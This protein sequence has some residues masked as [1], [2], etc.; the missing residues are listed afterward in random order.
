MD[1]SDG[2]NL[3][4]I[5]SSV[6]PVPPTVL[7]TVAKTGYGQR[8]GSWATYKWNGKHSWNIAQM[9]TALILI[10]QSPA[11]KEWG[12]QLAEIPSNIR[13]ASDA[14]YSAGCGGAILTE[15]FAFVEWFFARSR[16][17]EDAPGARVKWDD[18][19]P[20]TGIA[21]PGI[22]FSCN[23]VRKMLYAAQ[24]LQIQLELKA[25]GNEGST[26]C[27]IAEMKAKLVELEANVTKL[28]S[29]MQQVSSELQQFQVTS[30]I[31]NID[32]Q[33]RAPTVT[34]LMHLFAEC[35]D[36]GYTNCDPARTDSANI[37]IDTASSLDS[38]NSDPTLLPTDTPLHRS[39]VLLNLSPVLPAPRKSTNSI[40]NIKITPHTDR[41]SDMSP[42]AQEW[43]LS[44]LDMR[45][46]WVRVTG[47]DSYD[48]HISW[49]A[50]NGAV[51]M[52]RKTVAFLY[53]NFRFW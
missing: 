14:R 37:D 12:V 45:T 11:G 46:V 20:L 32:I 3:A 31:S 41:L 53:G 48:N 43:F 24:E 38:S 44:Q 16:L 18:P 29:Q 49:T 26:E 10:E 5:V 42:D 25:K 27:A 30:H 2:R 33:N 21:H 22:A 35:T 1:I 8:H 7:A 9:V 50:F 47:P 51:E 36:F 34:C 17:S 28:G 19:E 40:Y 4:E 23:A 39:S 15:V 13:T 52:T 6:P